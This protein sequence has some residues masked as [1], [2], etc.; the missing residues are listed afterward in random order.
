[1]IVLLCD[2]NGGMWHTRAKELGMNYI[3]MP[4]T[5]QDKEYYYDLGEH[6]DIV[7]FYNSVRHGNI[8]TTSALNP[9]LYCDIIEPIFSSGQDILYVSFS[10][11]LSGTFQHLQTAISQLVAKYPDRKCTVF[12]TNSISL[13]AGMQMEQAVL[14][15]NNGA[16]DKEIVSFL[17]TFTH[18]VAV[19][20]MVDDLMHLKRGGRLTGL[21]A[22]MGT[23]MGFKPILTVSE[24]GGLQVTK[25]INGKRK[26]L[27]FLADTVIEDL[28]DADQ[29]TVYIVDAD[30]SH[31][32]EYVS[33]RISSARPDANIVRQIVGP[34]IGAHCGPGTIGVIFVANSRPMPLT[35]S[36]AV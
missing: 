20:F 22:T 1:M 6:I 29:Y 25:K 2:S 21:Q 19:Y 4:Y 8:P 15:H 14:M 9:E 32:G 13:G 17:E 26:A 7:D 30:S 34:V 33:Q 10:H 16:T 3:K 5:L 27:N 24:S 35:D 36:K 28:V 23:L 18:K 31:D 11:A 12:N